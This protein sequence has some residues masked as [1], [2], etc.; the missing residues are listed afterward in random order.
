LSLNPK[1]LIVGFVAVVLLGF[2][3]MQVSAHEPNWDDSTNGTTAANSG[4]LPWYDSNTLQDVRCVG[5]PD[6]SSP[7]LHDGDNSCLDAVP[8]VS[9]GSFQGSF[10]SFGP[11]FVS[12]GTLQPGDIVAATI[13]AIVP[14]CNQHSGGTDPN[15]S[16]DIGWDSNDVGRWLGAFCANA[17]GGT[18]DFEFVNAPSG[19]VQQNAMTG[20]DEC[21]NSVGK[22]TD[23]LH[24]ANISATS[25]GT[26][27][28]GANGCTT[29]ETSTTTVGRILGCGVLAFYQCPPVNAVATITK[30]HGF[31]SFSFNILCIGPAA[32]ATIGVSPSTV[33]I[34]PAPGNQSYSR[35]TV[36][37][38]DALGNRLDGVEVDFITD[39]CWWRGEVASQDF[40]TVSPRGGL[41]NNVR[42]H[43]TLS[44]TDTAASSNEEGEGTA[45]DGAFINTTLGQVTGQLGAFNPTTG[46]PVAAGTAESV[47]QCFPGTDSALA[48]LVKPG[49]ANITAIVHRTGTPGLC[50]INTTGIAP[51]NTNS[52]SSLTSSANALC[53]PLTG[54]PI[55]FART[56][57]QPFFQEDIIL[58]ATVTVIGPPASI[59]VAA[60]PTSLR[61]GEKST[62]TATIKDAIGA[63]VSDHTRV[64][65]VTNLGGV[66]AGTGAVTSGLGAGVVPISSTVAETF[67]GVATAFLLTSEVTTGPYEVVVTAGGS[68]PVFS[69]LQIPSQTSFTQNSSANAIPGVFVFPGVGGTGSI[70]TGLVGP[71]Y[72]GGGGDVSPISGVQEPSTIG[73]FSTAPVSAQT[74]VTCSQPVPV[75]PA[76][77][78][79]ITAPRTGT[80]I[81]PPNTGDGGLA[82][83]NGSSWSL[84]ALAGIVAL[85][86]AGVATVR[87]SRR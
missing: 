42:T 60:S 66:L 41:D 45:Q 11:S 85:A 87:V 67:A 23:F 2:G 50:G 31:E 5:I 12:P 55:N 36:T 68:F 73:V 28:F 58:T 61:C 46:V 71:T 37:V 43:A 56:T 40:G 27:G 63:N 32:Q 72:V 34:V 54:F 14:I 52:L 62:I 65:L 47:L 22:G 78:P 38:A 70:P 80:G 1:T 59:T 16:A 44:D 76:P 15:P 74:T 57:F 77:A 69:G 79:Q 83:A 26:D 13:N 84:F 8:N 51:S 82:D 25:F 9:A 35:V 21:P 3:A 30:T 10:S 49:P 7:A 33:E 17:G 6:L 19:N 18:T 39:N 24:H 75:A 81:T 53:G 48:A 20:N 29:G 64:E 86:I 4:C